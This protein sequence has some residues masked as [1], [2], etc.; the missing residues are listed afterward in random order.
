MHIAEG[1]LSAPVLITGGALAVGGCAVGLRKLD[2]TRLMPTALLA[3]VFF[4]GCLLLLCVGIL[5]EYLART[6]TEAVNRPKYIIAKTNTN[7]S[8]FTLEGE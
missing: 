7:V 8:Y 6:Y 1:V 4:T 5:G 2:E 3:A